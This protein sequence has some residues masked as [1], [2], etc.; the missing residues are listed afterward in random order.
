ML[1][2]VD[3]NANE[4]P[5]ADLA[6]WRPS[7]GVWY[8]YNLVTTAWTSYSFGASGDKTVPG[9]YDGDGKTDFAVA[10]PNSGAYT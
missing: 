1:A 9:D 5:P 6:V 8:V 3:A 7:S 2:V 4:T 10:R